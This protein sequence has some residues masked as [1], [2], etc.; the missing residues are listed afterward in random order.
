MK[1]TCISD[2]HQHHKKV[3]V[4][5]SDVVVHAGDFTYR[6]ELK[7]VISFLDWYQKV[8]AEYKLLIC[9]NHEVW[10]SNNQQL[11]QELCA[12]RGIHLLHDRAMTIE[13][14]KF[15]GTPYTPNFGRWAYMKSEL[16]L[17]EVWDKIPLDT[18]VLITHGPAR[19]IL[20]LCPGGNV[21]SITLKSQLDLLWN[22]KLHV[23]GHIHESRGTQLVKNTNN[24]YL[25]V[26][27][28]ICGIPYT[29]VLINPITVTI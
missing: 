12:S 27:A 19:G 11:L 1:I 28:S 9:G 21:G 20:D 5:Q 4:P 25:S 22:L 10:I 17:V 14:L 26:N 29:D 2:T 16:E 23:M 3:I 6:G 7:E 13:G 8:P 15:Y 24:Q 18:D